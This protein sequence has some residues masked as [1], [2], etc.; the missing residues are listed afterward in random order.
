MGR[1]YNVYSTIDNFPHRGYHYNGVPV[2]WGRQA[3]WDDLAHDTVFT[4]LIKGYVPL[5]DHERQLVKEH[6]HLTAYGID[7]D[8]PADVQAAQ[9][10]YHECVYERD[11]LARLFTEEEAHALTRYL[12]DHF[13][14]ESRIVPEELPIERGRCGVWSTAFGGPTGWFELSD[15]DGYPLPFEVTGYFDVRHADCLDGKHPYNDPD[16]RIPPAA[17]QQ[18]E[19]S[20]S[21]QRAAAKTPVH[22]WRARRAAQ[23]LQ[24]L[25]EH[26]RA[27][28]RDVPEALETTLELLKEYGQDHAAQ[29]DDDADM[30]F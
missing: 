15:F 12:N 27:N 14:I 5:T 28:G 26:E 7:D 22:V 11:Y 23:A 8:S 9:N 3:R 29:Q 4:S 13:G 19:E 10:H 1:L 20:E 18:N 17:W 6:V 16:P 24:G 25:I 21:M 2:T 30:P